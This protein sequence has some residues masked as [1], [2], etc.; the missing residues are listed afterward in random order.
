[1]GLFNHEAANRA[2]DASDAPVQDAIRKIYLQGAASNAP[3]YQ[4]PDLT[5]M[6][7]SDMKS[8]ALGYFDLC[9]VQDGEYRVEIES[10][11]GDILYSADNVFVG[12]HLRT[13]ELDE[14]NSTDQLRDDVFL[15]YQEVTGRYPVRPGQKILICSTD[16]QYKVMPAEESV[17]QLM[18]AGG[19]KFCQTGTRYTDLGC[20]KHAVARGESFSAGTMVFAGGTIFSFDDD[21][22]TN[23]PG[24]TGWRRVVS[25]ENDADLAQAKAKTDLVSVTQP[26]NLDVV[27]ALVAGSNTYDSVNAGLAGTAD[28][29]AFFVPTGPGL[30]LYR[31]DA[32]Q[33][34]FVGWQGEIIFDDVTALKAETKEFAPG[35]VLRTRREGYAYTVAS[36][37]VT[38]HHLTV[39]GNKLYVVPTN[40]VFPVDALG[41]VDSGEDCGSALGALSASAISEDL[42]VRFGSGTYTLGGALKDI[43][44]ARGSCLR[45]IGERGAKLYFTNNMGIGAAVACETMLAAEV[46]RHDRFIEVLD[47]TGMEVGDL[48]HIHTDTRVETGWN[49]D[50]QCVRRIA[51]IEGATLFL[52]QPL[53]FFFATA[54][55]TTVTCY[56]RASAHIKGLHMEMT[57]AVQLD[58]RRLCDSS[59]RDGKVSGPAPGWSPNFS[60]GVKTVSCDRF[61]Y[62]GVDL[63]KLRYAPVITTGSRHVHVKNCVAKDV[64]HLDASVWAQD[65]LFED[66]T[67]ISTDGIIQCHPCIRP[68]F[69]RV[70]DSVTRTGLYGIDLRGLGEV[71]EDCVVHH[72]NAEVSGNTNAPLLLPEYDAMAGEFTRRITRLRAPHTKIR[73]GKE[74]RFI[75]EQSDVGGLDE[76]QYTLDHLKIMVDDLT[77]ARDREGADFSPTES[78]NFDATVMRGLRANVP[79]VRQYRTRVALSEIK[80]I[81]QAN[82]AEV[83][84]LYPHRL[85]TG[86]EVLLSDIEGMVELNGTTRAVTVVNEFTVMLDG[87]DSTAFQSFGSS[88]QLALDIPYNTIT[89][90]AQTSPAVVTCPGHGYQNG[91]VI[92]IDGVD[93]MT[94]INRIYYVVQSAAQDSFALTGLDGKGIEGTSLEAYVSGGIVTLQE[95]VDTIEAATKPQCGIGDQLLLRSRIWTGSSNGQRFYRFPVK[96]RAFGGGNIDQKTRWGVL[97]VIATS[98]VGRSIG[99]FAFDYDVS[100]GT[101]TLLDNH[102][103]IPNSLCVVN[104]RHA[105]QHF[106]DQVYQEGASTWT[107][108]T[109]ERHYLTFDIEID[110]NRD[111][112]YLYDVFVEMDEVRHGS[113]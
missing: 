12:S 50:K 24:L 71:V 52:D 17:P 75:V 28:G 59:M 93:G 76:S 13:Q 55:A 105:Q 60:D 21:G 41:V 86:D 36:P 81:S 106:I 57:A 19:V 22:N 43:E 72:A 65:I 46:A 68:V 96:Y 88:G 32:G 92:W 62:D 82:P 49:Y 7:V 109:G 31:N 53:E 10:P 4:D 77:R 51:R 29:D 56:E 89:G 90:I 44:L 110:V 112:R 58:F 8:D 54:V 45:W 5:I 23:L 84:T 9:Y 91:D 74:G 16:I 26:V 79:T 11:Q 27:P 15:S 66:I 83:T 61:V 35:L 98:N 85:R 42:P 94:D 14:Y 108:Q 48:L 101:F 97:R 47:S 70:S 111:T 1:M 104:V 67:G 103:H 6:R 78:N 102:S 99:E 39:A 73:A 95:E 37:L 3:A 33:G 40:G 2:L 30:Q 107:D 34:T 64:R 18:S 20:F 25:P 100:S 63:E 69:R 87:V 80:A 113:I 38:D